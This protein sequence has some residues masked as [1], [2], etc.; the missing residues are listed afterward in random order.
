MILGDTEDFNPKFEAT[1]RVCEHDKKILMLHRVDDTWSH[2]G[3]KIEHNETPEEAIL[4]EIS[5]ETGMSIRKEQ[6]NYI[7]KIQIRY[8]EFDFV[9]HLIYSM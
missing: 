8:L 9:Y 6:L 3:G 2:P 7:E 1:G 5:E 4:R